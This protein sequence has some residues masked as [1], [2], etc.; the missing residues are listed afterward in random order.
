LAVY[1]RILADHRLA[2]RQV[3]YAGDDLPDLPVMERVGLA[4]AVGSAQPDVRRAAHWVTRRPGGEGAVREVADLL[5]ACLPDRQAARQGR[6]SGR[7][8]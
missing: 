8:S 4:I 2:D 7:A 6:R 3:A 1:E 5:L